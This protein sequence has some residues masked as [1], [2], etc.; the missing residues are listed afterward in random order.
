[1]KEIKT[2]EGIIKKGK[3]ERKKERKNSNKTDTAMARLSLEQDVAQYT[4]GP[5]PH[6]PGARH[7]STC[8]CTTV[9]NSQ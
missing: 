3:K 5:T 9:D 6:R 7:N 1:M 2:R 8:L 4:Y